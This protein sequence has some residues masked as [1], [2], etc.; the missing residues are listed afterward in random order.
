[1]NDASHPRARLQILAGSWTGEEEVFSSSPW[2]EP[3]A[4]GSARVRAR[5][6]LDGAFLITDYEVE[7]AGQI[8]FRGHGVHGYDT[9][10]GRY[11]MYW[12]DALSP[13]Y[14]QPALGV[15]DGD[16]LTFEQTGEGGVRSRWVYTFENPERYR[17]R[18]EHS[19]DGA[20]WA[21]T[22]EA[23]YHKRKE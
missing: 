9:E 22:M 18:M 4:A 20:R 17:F 8:A 5:I 21:T 7:R 12:F 15:W 2:G 3:G 11:T 16:T 19:P 14:V 6:D 13:G 23:V 1:M 10:R